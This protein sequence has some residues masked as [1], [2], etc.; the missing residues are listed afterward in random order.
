[1]WTAY[2]LTV[3]QA[4]LLLVI[5]I[6]PLPFAAWHQNA[7]VPLCCKYGSLDIFSGGPEGREEVAMNESIAALYRKTRSEIQNDVRSNKRK[8]KGSTSMMSSMDWSSP[9]GRLIPAS[10]IRCT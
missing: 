10:T 7:G 2:S 4:V 1:M 6:E 5:P 3:C 8:K 9:M